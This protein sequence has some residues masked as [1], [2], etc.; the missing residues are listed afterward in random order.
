MATKEIKK[1]LKEAGVKNSV[2]NNGN[3]SVTIKSLVSDDVLEKIEA[4]STLEAHGDL[5][6]DTRFYTGSGIRI[7]FD[8]EPTQEQ[9][10]QAI[11]IKESFV[12]P[13]ESSFD[14]NSVNYHIKKTM[15]EKMGRALTDRIFYKIQY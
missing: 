5:I 15:A 8:F 14:R 12:A 2:R 11:K 6:D 1:I 3:I 4:F 10:N 9:I 13:G 7:S